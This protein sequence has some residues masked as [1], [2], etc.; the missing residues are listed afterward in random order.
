MNVKVSLWR[1]ADRL[2][3]ANL[4][5]FDIMTGQ[6]ERRHKGRMARDVRHRG[7]RLRSARLAKLAVLPL[8]GLGLG[9]YAPKLG[10]IRY[11]WP[12]ARLA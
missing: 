8:Q 9:G 7:G 3:V 6:G 12:V 2:P 1:A 5:R 4:E 11:F 10:L